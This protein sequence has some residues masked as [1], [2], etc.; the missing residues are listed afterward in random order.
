MFLSTPHKL[1]RNQ[2]CARTSEICRHLLKRKETRGRWSFYKF[3][4]DDHIILD[5]IGKPVCSWGNFLPASNAINKLLKAFKARWNIAKWLF[6][7]RNTRRFSICFESP[8]ALHISSDTFQVFL[9]LSISIEKTFFM[10]LFVGCVRS[11]GKIFSCHWTGF[12][13][14]SLLRLDIKFNQ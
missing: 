3:K 14:F 1:I 2:H 11:I 12:C 9:N 13:F 10:L 4:S 6:I 8:N 7:S 5:V